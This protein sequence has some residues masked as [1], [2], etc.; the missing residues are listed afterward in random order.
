LAEQALFLKNMTQVAFK[1]RDGKVIMVYSPKGGTGVTTIAVNLGF[2]LNTE[3]TPVLILDSNFQFGDVPVFINEHAKSSILDLATRS[4]ELE[5]EFVDEVVSRHSK[6]SIRYLAAPPRLEQSEDVLPE[7]YSAVLASLR[8]M[9]SYVVIDSP[10][11]VNEVTLSSID[12]A[13]IIVLLVT[14]DIPAIRNTQI[15]LDLLTSLKI[16][17]SKIIMAMNKFDKR[18]SITTEKVSENLKMVIPISIGLDEKTVLTSVNRGIPFTQEP[19][20]ELVTQQVIKL[21]EII[22]EKISQKE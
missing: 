15:F 10:H 20:Q 14:Q 7:Q 5:P 11:I 16:P 12:H 13:D 21:S 8:E 18:I 2:A 22:V 19:N 17:K 1:K 9:Y 3:E 6:S 4:D